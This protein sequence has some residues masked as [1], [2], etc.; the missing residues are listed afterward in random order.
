MDVLTGLLALGFLAVAM[1]VLPRPDSFSDL[2][3][4]PALPQVTGV[5][6]AA[7]P[8]SAAPGTTGRAAS[9]SYAKLPLSFVPNKG[10]TDESVR[11]YAQG[12]GFGFFF[13]D[14][15]AVLSLQRQ[16]RGQALALR[17]LGSSTHATLV[18]R[19][20]S[21]GKIS[22]L[23][24]DDP[25]KWHTG[26]PTYAQLT[27]RG[28]WPG[29][30]MSFRGSG[31][32]LE[33]EFRLKPGASAE[34]VRLAYAGAEGLSLT[35]GGSLAIR[36][37]LGTLRDAKPRAW[38]RIGGRKVPVRSRFSLAKGGHGA[39]AF[40]FK[41]GAY[42]RSRPLVIDPGVAYS[43]YLGGTGSDES[44]GIAVDGAG[45]AYVT[46]DTVSSDFPTTVGTFDTDY[47]GGQDAF[48][49]KLDSAGSLVY[50][51]VLGGTSSEVGKGIALD[52]AGNAYVTG[53]TFSSDFPTTAGAFDT[54]SNGGYDA[55]VTKL[56]SSGSGLA[57][58]T[59]L[60]GTGYDQGNGIA[61]D[62]AGS[63]YVTGY[64]NSPFPTT[65]GA[66]DTSFNGAYDAFVTK[67]DSSGA[68]LAYS[69]YLGQTAFDQ[70]NDIAVD[71]A[72]S[73]YVTGYFTTA[74]FPTTAGAF[75]TSF[76]GG[77]DAFVTKLDS[78]GAALVY[79]TYLGGTSDD[80]GFGI[81]VDGAGSAY[82]TG[83][84]ASAGPGTGTSFPTTTGAFDTTY[85]GG[86]DGFVTKLGNTGATLSYSTFLGGTGYDQ[87]NGVAVDGSG[88]AYVT[89]YTNS[90]PGGSVTDVPFPTSAGAFD[91]T[92]N[93]AYDAFLTKV[94]VAGATLPYST[95]L[96][97]T[98][99]DFGYAIAVDG[100]GEGAYLTGRTASGDFPTGA[101]F[102]E[103]FNG[104]GDAFV[105]KFDVSPVGYAR[106]KSA[107]P[108]IVRLV[109]AYKPC[110]VGTSVHGAPLLAPSC[111]PPVQ[112]SDYLTVGTPD[113]NGKI[114]NSTGYVQLQVVGESPINPNNGDQ[115]D[116]RITVQL[117][118]VRNKG[119]LSDYTGELEAVLGLR[120]TDRLNGPFENLPATVTDVPLRVPIG[121]AETGDTT[122]GGA[123]NLVT[124]VNTLTG[125]VAREGK[126]AIWEL[127]QVRVFDGGTDGDVETADNTLFAVQGLFAP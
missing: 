109:P 42:D 3:Q 89:G 80:D 25:R 12:K 75:D 72:G 95:F 68:S 120:I 90:T 38:Q 74:G 69:T 50:S 78:A 104:T 76:N 14:H 31:G 49:T 57:Y 124:S 79:S 18:P 97:G 4:T 91:T 93:G 13:A 70:G 126:R 77:F 52:G 48:V 33:Y 115:A 26:L 30:D 15:K 53:D 88:R 86:Y 7:G 8:G 127:A 11:Y 10:Q 87:G 117:T 16:E 84:T 29:V 100:A 92:Y 54:G 105:T 36:T 119:G 99:G 58:S 47:N 28:L 6:Q 103:T 101:A 24:G 60:G 9:D 67:L 17:F 83:Y 63:A 110:S 5:P 108:T 62:G 40:G 37:P 32:K 94:D 45:S 112:S 46:G 102:D 56:D 66:F 41:L 122:N 96:G 1:A 39:R 114:A 20:Q 35:A 73:A 21:Q 2:T 85:N 123:C 27:Y 19:R 64:T 106:P 44:F 121:C 81:A 113:S 118:D 82:V 71:G 107:T 98:G 111:S 22:Y 55:F 23:R 61:V 65:A 59:Y 43:T 116:V 34:P 125:G 51:T